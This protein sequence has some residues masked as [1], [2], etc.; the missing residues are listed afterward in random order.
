MSVVSTGKPN[1]IM[2]GVDRPGG[3]VR[4][5][6]SRDIPERTLRWAL[7]QDQYF[8]GTGWHID[9]ELRQ[10]L[11]IDRPTWGEAYAWAFEVWANQDRAAA[12]AK[13]VIDSYSTKHELTKTQKTLPSPSDKG[14]R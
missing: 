6:A 5:Y 12:E 10:V 14:A 9:A 4:L 7:A 2:V 8:T 11:I 3:G 13:A 1:H